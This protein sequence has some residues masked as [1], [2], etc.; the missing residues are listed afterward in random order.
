MTSSA[1][2]GSSAFGGHA[3]L[4]QRRRPSYPQSVF[5]ALERALEGPRER[6]ADLGAG[7][8]QATKELAKRFAHVTA[9]EP[10]ARMVSEFPAIENVDVVNLGSEQATFA[11]GTLDAVI[12]ATSFHWMGQAVVIGRVHQWLRPG[13][14]F[15]PFLYD[16]F[17]VEGA[18]KDVYRRHNALW[19]PYKDRRLRENVDYAK[20]FAA[21]GAFSNWTAFH[22]QIGAVLSAEDAAGLLATTSFGSAYARAAYGEPSIYFRELADEFRACGEPLSIVAPLNG[23]IAIK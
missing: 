17:V 11:P 13:G 15:F 7:S 4:Y 6:A 3:S 18:A 8:G 19:E 1:P 21:S 23:V 9:I 12:A 22:D 2:D 16:A 14:V 5:D 20:A 10:D